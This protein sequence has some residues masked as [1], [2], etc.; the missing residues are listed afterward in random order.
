MNLI[1]HP[2][3]AEVMKCPVCGLMPFEAWHEVSLLTGEH[4]I[5]KMKCKQGHEWPV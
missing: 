3:D 4:N 5:T 2:D 1:M